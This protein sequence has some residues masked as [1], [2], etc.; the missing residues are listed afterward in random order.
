MRSKNFSC[1]LEISGHSQL[2][3]SI[4]FVHGLFGHPL[5]TWTS[6]PTIPK[7]DETDAKV[8]KN[9]LYRRL[10]NQFPR[11]F[12]Y[13]ANGKENDVTSMTQTQDNQRSMSNAA[14][15]VMSRDSGHSTKGVFWPKDLL[16]KVIPDARM[17][18]YG[19]DVNINHLFSSASQATV[20]QHAASFLNDLANERIST[21]AVSVLSVFYMKTLLLTFGMQ[22]SRPLIFVAHSL[23]GILV[24]DVGIS[25]LKHNN[26]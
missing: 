13:K 18:T 16:P 17:F 15:N 12:R 8:K 10:S 7:D 24:K 3:C 6:P 20:F 11:V 26:R 4:I 19:Y 14:D 25:Q 23:G 5:D 21:E 9:S 22:Q 1:A 2:D